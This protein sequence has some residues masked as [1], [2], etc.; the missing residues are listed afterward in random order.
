MVITVNGAPREVPDSLSLRQVLEALSLPSL[1]RGV[2]VAVNGELVRR[3]D[4]EQR[5][6][7]DED[8][9]EIVSATQGG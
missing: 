4:W 9:L 7:R 2:A 1:E 3:A 6:V 5:Q 8:R